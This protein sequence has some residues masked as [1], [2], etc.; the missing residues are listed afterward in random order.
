MEPSLSG[1][2]VPEELLKLSEKG[3]PC[4]PLLAIYRLNSS[5]ANSRQK[6]KYDHGRLKGSAL[7]WSIWGC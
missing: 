6:P 7:S 5:L 3:E 4:E 1:I 2:L